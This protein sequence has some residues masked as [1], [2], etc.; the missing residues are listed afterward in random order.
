VAVS[1]L[2]RDQAGAFAQA[3]RLVTVADVRRHHP[4]VPV[5]FGQATGT[6]WAMVG[7]RFVEAV[8]LA[9]LDRAI[10]CAGA[11]PWPRGQ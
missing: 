7:G 10:R 4:G 5:W 11:W 1:I 9:E 2:T 6:W 8:D 3:P